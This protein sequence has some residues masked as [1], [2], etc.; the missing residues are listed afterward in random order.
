M[1]DLFFY[2]KYL[3]VKRYFRK[4]GLSDS[5]RVLGLGVFWI[6]LIA[7]MMI[8]LGTFGLV[9]LFFAFFF[10]LRSKGHL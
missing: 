8:L 4:V 9:P 7:N 6:Q 10:F 5:R 3:A 1:A 2:V